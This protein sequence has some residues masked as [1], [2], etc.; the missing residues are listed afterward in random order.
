EDLYY[1]LRVFPLRVPSLRERGRDIFELADFFTVSLAADLGLEPLTF[2]KAAQKALLAYSWP[3]NVRELKNFIERMLILY[4]GKEIQV[5]DLPPEFKAGKGRQLT[6]Q[7]AEPR[8]PGRPGAAEAEAVEGGGGPEGAD[9]SDDADPDDDALLA[10]DALQ[11]FKS[12]RSAFEARFLAAKLKEHDGNISR[13]AEAIG[14]ERS[15]LSRKLKLYNIQG[16]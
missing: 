4:A 7:G 13:L 2:S 14:L 5:A 9:D 15:H 12:A 10:L 3:G 16:S 11:D 6:G 8:P 1:R